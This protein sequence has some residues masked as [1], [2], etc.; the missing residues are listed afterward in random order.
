MPY[1]VLKNMLKT[2]NRFHCIS[3][4]YL[5]GLIGETE[6]KICLRKFIPKV[7]SEPVI[8]CLYVVYID[9]GLSIDDIANIV[10]IFHRSCLNILSSCMRMREES[11]KKEYRQDQ[12]L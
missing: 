4:N 3:Q 6:A 8:H 1:K 7:S 12:K 11:A 9:C 5:S 10:S 2:A